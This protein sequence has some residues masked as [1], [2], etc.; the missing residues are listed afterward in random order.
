MSLLCLFERNTYVRAYL[1]IETT[2]AGGISIIGIYRPDRGTIQLIGG[3][4]HD[5]ALFEALEDIETL[6]T[7]NG[8][9][10]DLPVIRKRLFVDLKQEFN[11]CDLMMVCRRHGLRGGLKRIEEHLG[12]GRVT[13]G[14]S[15]WDAPRLWRRYEAYNDQRALQALL[16]YNREDVLNLALLEE[17]IGLREAQEPNHNIRHIYA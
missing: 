3:G 17:R 12:I 4:V 13:A 10:F 15:G 2:M 14:I 6:I 7:F 9:S 1:D 5:L 11:H 16:E 8:N